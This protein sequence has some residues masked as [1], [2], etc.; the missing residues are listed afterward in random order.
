MQ[1]VMINRLGLS[2]RRRYDPAVLSWL[3]SVFGNGGIVTGGELR[4]IDRFLRTDRDWGIFDLTDDYVF[5]KLSNE[6]AAK[7]TV[8]R[9]VLLQTVNTPI[10]GMNQGFIT[11]GM[12]QCLK[13]MY[14]PSSD[15]VALT[16]TSQ[17]FGV[18]NLSAG[19]GAHG[20]RGVSGNT[21]YLGVNASVPNASAVLGNNNSVSAVLPTSAGY[22]VASMS[23]TAGNAIYQN[24]VQKG[25]SAYNTGSFKTNGDLHIGALLTGSTLGNW[26][27][28]TYPFA[29]VGGAVSAAQ[30]AAQSA[31]VADALAAI[32]ALGGA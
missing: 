32:A 25:A 10:F 3:D 23:A 15:G 21:F 19:T 16:A 24:G 12:S 8:K 20:G 5:T 22:I 6:I 31:N 14:R 28:G 13:M 27:A 29:T 9:R 4:V 18:F 30:E 7:T 17:R 26:V 2:G 11:D 1:L